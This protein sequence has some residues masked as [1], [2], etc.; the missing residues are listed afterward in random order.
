M[1]RDVAPIPDRQVVLITGHRMKN[2][3][4]MPGPVSERNADL[5]GPETGIGKYFG[6]T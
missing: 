6:V 1:T 4:G 5:L 2:E 3:A